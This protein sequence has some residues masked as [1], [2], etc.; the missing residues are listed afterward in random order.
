VESYSTN[1]NN[2]KETLQRIVRGEYYEPID[3]LSENG[4]N[5][6]RSLLQLVSILLFILYYYVI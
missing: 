2:V 1:Q 6:L 4:V 3:K 5:F